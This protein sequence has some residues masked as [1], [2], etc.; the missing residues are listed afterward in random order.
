MLI[1]FC[2]LSERSREMVGV[3]FLTDYSHQTCMVHPVRQQDGN[4]SAG[5]RGASADIIYL[6]AG[7]KRDV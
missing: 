5:V 3:E 4:V 1:L 6:S 7:G 2:L